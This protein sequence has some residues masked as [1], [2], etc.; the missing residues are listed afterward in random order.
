MT[1]ADSSDKAIAELIALA[2]RTEQ[3]ER[4]LADLKAR[5][6]PFHIRLD[7]REEIA[8]NE[9]YVAF[10]RGLAGYKIGDA[11]ASH[12]RAMRVAPDNPS[13]VAPGLSGRVY[14]ITV[15]LEPEQEPRR[16]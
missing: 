9:S 7:A 11:M 4:E 6:L 15:L 14:R 2:T 5:L 10:E 16:G 8:G 12:P 1:P 3:A 13:L